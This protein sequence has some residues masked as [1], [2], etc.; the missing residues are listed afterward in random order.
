MYFALWVFQK[1]TIKYLKLLRNN[2]YLVGNLYVFCQYN[3]VYIFT[4]VYSCNVNK[5]FFSL[6]KQNFPIIYLYTWI[7][8]LFL[9]YVWDFYPWKKGLFKKHVMSFVS[10]RNREKFSHN[11]HFSDPIGCCPALGLSLD[12][13]PLS[14]YK[15]PYQALNVGYSIGISEGWFSWI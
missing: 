7:Y 6:L 1:V 2:E 15:K 10:L 12:A 9:L 11:K 4:C 8:F 14:W 13:T 3:S 5:K